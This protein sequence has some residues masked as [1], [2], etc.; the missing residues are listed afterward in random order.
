VHDK[1]F[2]GRKILTIP[3]LVLV[4][5]FPLFAAGIMLNVW[6]Y[7]VGRKV[8]DKKVTRIDFYT[9]VLVAVSAISFV[10]WL[11]AWLL[12]SWLAASAWMAIVF[13]SAPLFAWFALWWSDRYADWTWQQQYEKLQRDEP[14]KIET[15][16]KMR[17]EILH[18]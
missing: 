11:I 6:P 5:C 8:A 16:K 18:C 7:L 9:S 12:V 3:P 15:F 17:Q 14:L 10:I 2:A 1:S 13:L 4:L